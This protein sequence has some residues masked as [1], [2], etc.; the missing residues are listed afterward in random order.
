MLAKTHI[1]CLRLQSIIVD[2]LFAVLHLYKVAPKTSR[3][4]ELSTYHD[5]SY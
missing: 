4:T 2:C 3:Y 5:E 1:M